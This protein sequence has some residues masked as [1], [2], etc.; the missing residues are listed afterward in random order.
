MFAWQ[1]DVCIKSDEVISQAESSQYQVIVWGNVRP[2]GEEQLA[3]NKGRGAVC[4]LNALKRYGQGFYS[5]ISGFFA[6][7]IYNKVSHN[8]EL[9]TDHVGSMPLFYH[10][11]E[12][13]L[14]ISNSLNVMNTSE[15]SLNPQA[16]FNYCYYHCIAAPTTIYQGVFKLEAGQ[17]IRIETNN[18][19]TS[20][21]LYQ[22]RYQY[23]EEGDE[24]LFT[25]CR[26]LVSQAVKQQLSP[27]CGAFLSG[28]LDSSTVAGMLKQVQGTAKTFSIG[29][30]QKE[31]DESAYAQLTADHFSTQHHRLVLQPQALIDNFKA[32]ASYFDQPFGNSSAMAAYS[33]ATFAKSHGVTHLLAGDGGDEI[34]AGNER[35]AQQRIFEHFHQIPNIA[36]LILTTAFRPKVLTNIPGLKKVAS[37]LKQANVPLPDRLDN[38]NFM[39]QFP[40]QEMFTPQFLA[41][42][43]IAE[44]QKQRQ[45]RYNQAKTQSTLEKM[46]FLD[47]QHTLADNDLVKVSKMCQKAGIEVSY[48]LLEKELVDFSCCISP[49]KKL[50]GNQLRDFYKR[51]FR[52]FLSNETLEKE[53]HGFGLPF[54]VWMKESKPL[55][56][57][58][59]DA[60]CQLNKRNIFQA[61]F[62][63]QALGKHQQEHTS[64]YGELIWI[65]VILELW[66]E[67]RGL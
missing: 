20:K 57:M 43:D 66:L 1:R 4:L 15:L 53:K 26:S 29:F 40:L 41:Q 64:Y 9:I 14:T 11:T 42:V 52:G 37:Y 18:K 8:I 6:A 62:L 2:Y 67:S 34:F 22:P 21:V 63:K 23:S 19:L 16:I 28:G 10:L 13:E 51:A 25:T 47:W 50:A 3:S 30:E 48:P 46:L 17:M 61:H 5:R 60:L 45:A 36:Q 44:P 49:G 38:Y 12:H 35:Y 55:M 59:E 27:Q 31:Y 54:G 58:A 33:C 39:N 65:L 24:A 56:K 32:I 7:V